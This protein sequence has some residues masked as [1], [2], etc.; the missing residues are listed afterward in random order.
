MSNVTANLFNRLN[1]DYDFAQLVNDRLD[2][3]RWTVEDLALSLKNNWL[4]GMDARIEDVIR[5]VRAVRR[6]TE[7]AE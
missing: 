4:T 1:P 5:D 3:G 6:S 2:S 7:K